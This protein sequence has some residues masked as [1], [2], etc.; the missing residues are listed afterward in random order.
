MGRRIRLWIR[1]GIGVM[2]QSGR[3]RFGRSWGGRRLAG[4]E[5]VRT[6][7]EYSSAGDRTGS[8]VV[9]SEERFLSAPADPFAGS[10]WGR[11]NRP[12]PFGMTG[13]LRGGIRR[14]GREGLI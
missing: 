2:W 12:A 5:W 13:S 1:L 6:Q 7:K 3:R 10:E 8:S 11:K 14:G 9:A 4:S